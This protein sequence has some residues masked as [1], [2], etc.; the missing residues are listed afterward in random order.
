MATFCGLSSSRQ[1]DGAA[2]ENPRLWAGRGEEW[3]GHA[4]SQSQSQPW[5]GSC[6]FRVLSTRTGSVSPFCLSRLRKI[7][8]LAGEAWA[9]GSCSIELAQSALMHE[10]LHSIESR[11]LSWQLVCAG[12]PLP[13]ESAPQ[14]ALHPTPCPSGHGS[15][16]TSAKWLWWRRICLTTKLA[17][18]DGQR[19][20]WLTFPGGANKKKEVSIPVLVKQGNLDPNLLP[21]S[22][23]S[24]YYL[25]SAF[26]MPNI[27][28]SFTR[29]ALFNHYNSLRWTLVP[30][31]QKKQLRRRHGKSPAWDQ[32]AG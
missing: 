5:P 18:E 27:E 4:E 21:N 26:Q 25:S 3:R 7:T 16:W 9:E 30:I 20:P 32:A 31:F 24:S 11:A 28:L 12:N 17:R 10:L 1:G 23:N 15:P 13:S 29:V 22:G 2:E 19:G 6:L 14:S 8:L